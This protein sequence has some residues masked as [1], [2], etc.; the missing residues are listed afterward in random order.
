MADHVRAL[1]YI[2]VSTDEQARSGLGLDA[3]RRALRAEA[4]RHGWQ[5]EVVV[6]D[7][8][9]AKDLNR[10][11][12]QAALD[13][14]DRHDADVLVV[15]KLDRLSRSVADFG[16]LLRRA[17]KRGWSVVCLDLGVDTATPSGELFANV[18]ASMSQY[19]RRL[20]GQRTRD[21]LAEKRAQGVRLGR[22]QVLPAG[23]VERIVREQR[24]GRSLGAIA[25]GLEHDGVPTARGGAWSR[26]SVQSVLRS[27]A[28]AAVA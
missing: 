12:L 6:E 10:P 27:Q 28:A 22:P 16:T 26:A 15:S 5:L 20:I 3:Q 21:A 23:V 2:R 18:V 8:R 9:S 24:A 7:G 17:D 1:G 11:V 13:R 14:L 4:R 25:A 19:E